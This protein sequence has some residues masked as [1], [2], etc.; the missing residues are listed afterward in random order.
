MIR[1]YFAVLALIIIRKSD[2][3]VQGYH[4]INLKFLKQTLVNLMS[5]FS[6]LQLNNNKKIHF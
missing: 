2:I 1:S 3:K 6:Q 4:L 5:L